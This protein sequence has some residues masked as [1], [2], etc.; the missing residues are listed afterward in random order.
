MTLISSERQA[1]TIDRTLPNIGVAIE[2]KYGCMSIAN[3]VHLLGL[4]NA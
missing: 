4:G 1:S 3:K 2:R